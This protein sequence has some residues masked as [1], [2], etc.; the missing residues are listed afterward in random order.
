[1]KIPSVLKDLPNW[2][3]WGPDP[4]S[5]RPKCPLKLRDKTRRASTRKP[6][7]WCGWKVAQA[8]L[9]KYGGLEG[10]G[11]GFV[12]TR[13]AGLVYVD[14]DD[15]L[16]REGEL[17]SWAEPFVR[18]FAGRAYME[19]SPSG[20]GLH[21]ITRGTLPGGVVGGKANFPEAATGLPGASGKPRVPEVAMFVDGK[22]T[23]ITGEVWAGQETL[24]SAEEGT[25]AAAEV[26]AAAGIDASRY[27]VAAG[28]A[29]KDEDLPVVGSARVPAV[30]RKELATGEE[31]SE[32]PDRSVARFRLFC[33]LFRAGLEAEE[34]FAVV[35][36]AEEWW[37]ASGAVEKGRHQVW[38]DV[39]RAGAKVETA[40]KEFAREEAEEKVSEA[41]AAA[42]WK[43]LGVPV[44]VRATKNGP[45]VEAVWGVRAMV[46]ALHGHPDWKGRLRWNTLKEVA[47]IDGAPLEDHSLS[48]VSEWLRGYLRWDHEPAQSLVWAALIEAARM[49]EY[50]PVADWL[51]G[52]R[53]D[54]RDRASDWLVR[55]G[56]EDCAVTRVLGR[57]WLI[58]LV[59]RALEPGCKV[60]TVLVL[61]GDQGLKK[62]SLFA[63]LAGKDWFTD[64]HANLDRDGVMVMAGHWIVE[65]A[66]LASVKKAEV[67]SVRSF[68]T[69]SVDAFRPP[70]GR[71]TV[72]KPRSFVIVGTT[73]ADAEGYLA[74]TAGNRRYWPVRVE[75]GRVIDVE[76]VAA[77]REQLLAEAVA[78]FR[79]GEKW[80]FETQPEALTAAQAAREVVD[81]LEESL[82]EVLAGLDAGVP[83]RV[84]PLLEALG[85]APDRKDHAMRVARL[86]KNRG[87]ERRSV[88][89]GGR[90]SWVWTPPGGGEK[91]V[92]P[93]AH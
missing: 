86:L 31:A 60:D 82:D 78:A 74:D 46:V 3:A 90:S 16:N 68:I 64:A 71:T 12:F 55:A 87:F 48:P 72:R 8:F 54:G 77:E 29:P 57:K 9:K 22:Y 85:L 92:T 52:L 50:R 17:R 88:W 89:L 61:E 11:V 13:A 33:D 34:V 28:P 10:W 84:K 40:A 21:I 37:A 32:A 83:V 15:A 39:L 65:L 24:G 2:I 36:G 93:K 62:S 67:E 20:R 4:D 91:E 75:K 47:E 5:G 7:T 19:R 63:A 73:N 81:P 18:P 38:A 69:R 43:D 1:M 35:R 6:E 30:A 49:R 25:R 51:E 26:W 58:S 56:C 80:Y 79:A 45:V 14:I 27:D 70:Y 59:A 23:T 44:T 66:E 76:G 53:W 42:G 41:H